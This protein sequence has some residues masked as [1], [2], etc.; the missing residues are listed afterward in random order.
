MRPRSENGQGE[1]DEQ[2]ELRELSVP[3]T[4]ADPSQYGAWASRSS[5]VEWQEESGG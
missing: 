3:T 4:S 5:V 1:Q 2:G